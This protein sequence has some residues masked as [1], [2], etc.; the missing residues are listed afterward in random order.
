MSKVGVM[1][2][3]VFCLP[4]ASGVLSVVMGM[5]Y[6]KSG[7][8]LPAGIMTGLRSESDLLNVQILEAG[9]IRAR[10][11]ERTG[12]YM[13]A[14][15][16]TFCLLLSLSFSLFM[17]FRL[18]LL[19][20]VWAEQQPWWDLKETQSVHQRT[21]PSV[22]PKRHSETCP[23]LCV[24]CNIRLISAGTLQKLSPVQDQVDTNEI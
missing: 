11:C 4:V 12:H 1:S 6:K 18:L 10:W 14:E 15:L 5:R 22:I 23:S 2:L 20:F 13:L 8:M 3:C 9:S 7:K 17:V 16:A 24:F 21:K 19:I